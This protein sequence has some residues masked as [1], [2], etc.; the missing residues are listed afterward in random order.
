[1]KKKKEKFLPPSSKYKPF[2]S[3]RQASAPENDQPETQSNKN[4]VKAVYY[5]DIGI[6][7][8]QVGR[9]PDISSGPAF[10]GKGSLDEII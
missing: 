6:K 4:L 7:T 5:I 10:L 2:R 8:A 9:D 3:L 1:M